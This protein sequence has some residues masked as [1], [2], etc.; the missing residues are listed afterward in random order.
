MKLGRKII[1]IT[2][3]G[4]VLAATLVGCSSTKKAA[5]SEPEIALAALRGS[6]VQTEEE[7]VVLTSAE[8]LKQFSQTHK[9]IADSDE[10]QSEIG[11]ADEEFFQNAILLCAVVPSGSGAE[12]YQLDEVT[13]DADAIQMKATRTTEKVGVAEMSQW[14]LVAAVPRSSLS[15]IPDTF[16]LVVE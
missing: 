11:T 6:F 16:T 5:D 2:L 13:L 3:V 14:Y 9:D 1:G 10:F 12:R 15:T 4:S 8:E 7:T